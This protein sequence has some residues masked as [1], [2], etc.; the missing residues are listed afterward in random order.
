[1]MKKLLLLTSGLLM[2]GNQVFGQNAP[3]TL[4]VDTLHYF[5]N[6]YH[7][8]TGTT[9]Q[10][11]P[12]YKAAAATVTNVTHCGSRFDNWDTLTINGLEAFVAKHP[13]TANLKIAVR[14]YLCTLDVNK[15]PVL[16]AIDSVISDGV[17]PLAVTSVTQTNVGGP[18]M[19]GPRKITTDFA[20]LFRNISTIAGDTLNLV[21]TAGKTFTSSAPW[22]EKNSDSYG[23]IRFGGQFKSTTNY[24][25]SQGFGYGTDYEFCVAPRVEYWLHAGHAL[26]S[27]LTNNPPDT[28]CTFAPLVFTNLSSKRYVH[29][30]YNLN[31]FCK[32]WNLYAPFVAAPQAAGGWTGDSSIVWKFEAE[33]APDGRVF[34]GYEGAA[35]AG[36]NGAPNT[37]TFATD[38]VNPD[39]SCFTAN[40]FRARLRPMC[41]YGRRPQYIYNEDFTMCTKYCN[42]TALAIRE[43]ELRTIRLFPNPLINGHSVVSGLKGNSS[44]MVYDVLG[45]LVYS[46]VTDKDKAEISL[47]DQPSG[48]YFVKIS[49]DSGTKVLKVIKQD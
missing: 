1:M 40:Q 9:L 18:L 25:L 34:L 20:V 47:V 19:H 26:P 35:Q 24:T 38:S 28:I 27:Q 43:D 39:S 41:I 8:K 46:S 13:K 30:Q 48:N 10:N 36:T 33:D 42:G 2:F 6:K 23:Y 17:A 31:E 14:L 3:D 5:F 21:R 16:P 37:I 32:K 29:R 49:N 44:I 45:Q 12:Y 22:T 15:M 4:V 7:F 11:F